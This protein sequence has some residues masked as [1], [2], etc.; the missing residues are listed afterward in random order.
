MNYDF[1]CEHCVAR[2]YR[3]TTGRIQKIN[4][5]FRICPACDHVRCNG[6]YVHKDQAAD[7]P[8]ESPIRAIGTTRKCTPEQADALMSDPTQFI[9][10]VSRFASGHIQQILRENKIPYARTEYQLTSTAD[11]LAIQELQGLFDTYN[12]KNWP[13]SSWGSQHSEITTSTSLLLAP[14]AFSVALKDICC[15][16]EAAGVHF[17]IDS[18]SI[19]IAHDGAP[20]VMTT[21]IT[22]W[23]PVLVVAD[24]ESI[25]PGGEDASAA[26]R[27]Y[28]LES[29]AMVPAAQHIE[30]NELVSAIRSSL[31][32]QNATAVYDIITEGHAVPP[33]ENNSW[34]RFAEVYDTT[35]GHTARNKQLADVLGITVKQVEAARNHIKVHMLA[36]QVNI[37]DRAPDVD[38]DTGHNQNF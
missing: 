21:T 18:H 13:S 28:S 22:K 35:R 6:Q 1:E 4:Q 26:Q 30:T 24:S 25:G 14:P 29:N 2:S 3:S 11:A 9:K 12:I 16:Y 7:L 8:Y 27:G 31:F 34:N 15:R 33:G 20:Q 17:I 10:L 32:D 38:Y 36:H 19:T 37:S 5:Q 23:N